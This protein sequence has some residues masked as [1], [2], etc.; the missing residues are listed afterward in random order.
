M[1]G[2]RSQ[3]EDLTGYTH[4]LGVHPSIKHATA[5]FWMRP[6]FSPIKNEEECA[7]R[8][9]YLDADNWRLDLES[10]AFPGSPPGRGQ[11]FSDATHPHLEVNK[12]ITSIPRVEPGDF[13][14]WHCGM[15]SLIGKW[16]LRLLIILPDGIHAVEAKHGGT[17]D[18]SVMYIGAAPLTAANSMSFSCVL[19]SAV[20]CP[21][22]SMSRAFM[23]PYNRL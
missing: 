20:Y 6:F 13:V 8:D 1:L 17:G 7:T 4:D 22:C 15:F 12:V 21:S 5:Y 2:Y 10:T 19:W 18:S 3:T 16:S 9:E 23:H 11:E 14:F